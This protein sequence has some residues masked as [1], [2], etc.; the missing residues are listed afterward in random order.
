MDS[1]EPPPDSIYLIILV[2][3]LILSMFFSACETAIISSSKLRIRYLKEKKNRAAARIEKIIEH[4][5]FFLNAILIGNNVVNIA[6]SSLLTAISVRIFGDAGIGI[7]TAAATIVI[8]IFGEILPKSIALMR[9]EKIA[10]R[11]SMPLSIF[12]ALMSPIVAIFSIVTS[13][14]SR[15]LGV[16]KEKKTV[17]VTEEDIKT[18][19]EIG[20]EEGLIETDKRDMMHR[21]LKYTDLTAK[22]I[23][24]PRTNIV[25]VSIDATRQEILDL[26]HRSRF[27]RFPVS[28]DNIDDIKGILY[29]K[30]F[31]FMPDSDNEFFEI[32]KLLRPAI[33]I[34][35]TQKISA[36]QSTLRAKK[37]N[38]AV[39]IDEYGGTAGLVSTDDLVKEIFGDIR[40]EY[41]RKETAETIR[42]VFDKPGIDSWIIDG[43]ER[44]DSLN[45]RFSVHLSSSFYDTL[46]GFIMERYGDI[47]DEGQTV[48]EQGF[49]FTVLEVTGNRIEKIRID[50][51][52]DR[53]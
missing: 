3:L 46:G 42:P 20:E 28:G 1:A 21:I 12:I 37:Q 24:I 35:E 23:M 10:L 45:E 43:N 8:L 7:A 30:D 47:P 34:F 29:V 13:F 22:D 53:E 16:K 26:S 40:D 39:V 41:D 32:E 6:S 17:T 19:I 9:P 52:G 33:F 25:A 44:L 36:L 27:S 48:S 18:L 38:M 14:F 15:L 49:S 51:T 31:I 4:K 2:A 50:R 11:V 5:D